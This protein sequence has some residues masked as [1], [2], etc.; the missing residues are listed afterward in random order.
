M[1]GVV[2]FPLGLAGS[3][4]FRVLGFVGFLPLLSVLSRTPLAQALLFTFTG[5]WFR[6]FGVTSPSSRS[7]AMDD[8]E[9][10]GEVRVDDQVLEPSYGFPKPGSMGTGPTQ[11]VF[12]QDQ[13][14]GAG[15]AHLSTG[16][17]PA[18]GQSE[19]T[20]VPAEVA[21][22]QDLHGPPQVAQGMPQ[23]AQAQA[24]TGG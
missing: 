1:L 9:N 5:L 15:A 6:F 14:T 23:V 10:L 12:I 3:S 11:E 2:W 19:V 4:G 22:I 24:F 17:S 21:H 20:Q 8:L 18:L 16:P 7:G 13:A